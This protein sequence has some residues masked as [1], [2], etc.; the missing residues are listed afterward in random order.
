MSTNS[1]RPL[2]YILFENAYIRADQSIVYDRRWETPPG[3]YEG[4]VRGIYAPKVPLGRTVSSMDDRGLKYLFIGTRFG[5][6]LVYEP[7]SNEHDN[8][9]IYRIQLTP[10][11]QRLRWYNGYQLNDELMLLSVGNDSNPNLG[12]KLELVLPPTD[13]AR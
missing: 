1:P 3:R 6:A 4:A 12:V 8:Q 7:V 5:N 2:M 11:I 13:E 9:V 10:D